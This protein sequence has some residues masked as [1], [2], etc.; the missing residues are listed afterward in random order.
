M[1]AI[2]YLVCAINFPLCPIIFY[3]WIF[4]CVTTSPKD[5]DNLIQKN[6]M[7]SIPPQKRE[8]PKNEDNLTPKLETTR[9][10]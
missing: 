10:Y 8:K 7:T 2:I 9:K 6:K 3:S 1:Y 4:M 5:E